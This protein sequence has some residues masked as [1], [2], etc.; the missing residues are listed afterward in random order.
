MTKELTSSQRDELTSQFAE[1]VDNVTSE[2][3]NQ[4]GKF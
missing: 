3:I 2:T 4:G 1:L